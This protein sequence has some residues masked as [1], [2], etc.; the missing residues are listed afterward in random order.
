MAKR[1]DFTNRFKKDWKRMERRGAKREKLNA[2]LDLLLNE[3]SLPERC[4][5]GCAC[6]AA[7][8]FC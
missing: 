1:L 7:I 5:P 4:R 8:K 2:V 3:D 6:V